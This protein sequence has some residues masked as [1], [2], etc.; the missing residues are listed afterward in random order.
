M[1]N[2]NQNQKEQKEIISPSQHLFINFMANIDERRSAI[3]L[4][5]ISDY[6]KTGIKKLS[7]NISS[8]GG[9]VFHAISLHNF[10]KGLK[11]VTVHTH[12]FGQVDSSANIVFLAGEIRTCSPASSF[13]FHGVK[14]IFRGPTALNSQE[15]SENLESLKS[16][17][18][19]LVEVISIST[20]HSKKEIS[21]FFRKQKVF[22]AKEAKDWGLAQEIIDQT[23]P[24]GFPTVVITDQS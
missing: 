16:D 11:G 2:Q 15:L 18:E 14:R 20:G 23:T 19:K 17:V 9:S 8:P 6:L 12:N 5:V 7:I 1:Q 4:S 13:L 10:I 3:L 21:S 24:S 22:A